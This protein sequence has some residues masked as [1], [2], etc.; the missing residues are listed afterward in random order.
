MFDRL[1][2]ALTLADAWEQLC[3]LLNSLREDELENSVQDPEKARDCALRVQG[4][5]N[6]RNELWAL[7][8]E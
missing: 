6:V 8:K 5:E 3:Q 7:H 4:I 2:E 1:R